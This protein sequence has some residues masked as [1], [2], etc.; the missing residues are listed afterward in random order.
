MKFFLIALLAI[1]LTSC[2][3]TPE[4]LYGS[5]QFN[6]PVRKGRITQGFK[7]GSRKHQGLDIS[8]TRNT[9]IYSAAQ[10]RVLYAGQGF[11]GY[12]KLIIIEHDGDRWA[13]FYAHLND[14]KV[15]EGSFV[16]KGQLIGLMG[17]TGRATG[18]HLHFEIRYN[19]RPVDPRPY[20]ARQT[21]SLEKDSSPS[22]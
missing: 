10:G 11:S 19:L 1:F 13:S 16:K 14:F 4:P 8:G 21:A 5:P 15:H 22:Q 9:P 6:W 18:V 17:R 20:M 2:A 7:R 3:S 12:G